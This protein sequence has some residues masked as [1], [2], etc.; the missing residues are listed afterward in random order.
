MCRSRAIGISGAVLMVVSVVIV[1]WGVY[2]AISV[3]EVPFGRDLI[4]SVADEILVLVLIGISFI[5]RIMLLLSLHRRPYY[6]ISASWLASALL[7]TAYVWLRMPPS[8]PPSPICGADG[9]C[10]TIYELRRGA[11]VL[12]VAAIVFILASVLRT[13]ATFVYGAVRFRYK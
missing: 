4:W 11:D 1:M 6:Q 2:Y 8:S 10:F 12:E 13:A 7:L 5:V 9:H 3:A